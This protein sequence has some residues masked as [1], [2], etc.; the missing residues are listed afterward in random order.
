MAMNACHIEALEGVE[1]TGF[2][3]DASIPTWAKPY[4]SSAL[5]SGLIQ[6]S[7]GSDGQVVFQADSPVTMAEAAVLLD[8]ML[9][10][11]DVAEPTFAASDVPAWASQSAANLISCGVISADN[12]GTLAMSQTLTRAD[13]AELLCGALD[14]LEQRDDGGWLWW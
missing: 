2:A 14:I 8:R 11:S 12:S 7:R 5:K 4:V 3:D 1:R 13:A 10:I 6:G 9:R